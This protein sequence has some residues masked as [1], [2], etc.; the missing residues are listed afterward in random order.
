MM[1][2]VKAHMGLQLLREYVA[3]SGDEEAKRHFN[4]LVICLQALEAEGQ[5]QAT[6]TIDEDGNITIG[7]KSLGMSAAVGAMA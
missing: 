1:N 2:G 4:A 3:D 5:R 6:T 7:L